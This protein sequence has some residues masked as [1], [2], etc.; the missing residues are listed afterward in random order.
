VEPG[1]SLRV[2]GKKAFAERVTVIILDV[3]GLFDHRD[4]RALSESTNRGGKIHVFVFHDEPEDRAPCAAAKA[5]IGLTLRINMKRG[6]FLPM[7]RAQS[8][9]AGSGPL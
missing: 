9:P 6:R 5:M 7:E 4:S 8:P 3:S 2:Q 1:G